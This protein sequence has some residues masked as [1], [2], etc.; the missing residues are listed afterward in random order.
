M[1]T[2][3]RLADGS[4][5]HADI[6]VV[7]SG[8]RSTLPDWL[9]AIGASPVPEEVE[10]TGIVYLSRFYRLRPGRDLPSRSGL[11]GGDL[12]YLKYG[13]FVGDNRTFSLTLAVP[14]DD[15]ELRRRLSEPDGFEAAARTLDVAAP[16][17]DG[18]AEALTPVHVMAGLLNRWRNFVIEGRPAALGVHAIGDALVCTN[19]LYG[20]GCTT[21]YWGAHLLAAAIEAAPDDPAEQARRYDAAVRAE[22][23]PWYTTGVA[24]DAEARRVAAALLAGEDPDGD[25]Q[26]PRAFMRGVLREGLA[27]ALRTD[28]VVLRAFMR[29]LNLLTSPNALMMDQEVSSRVLAVWQDREHRPPEPELGPATRAELCDAL[30]G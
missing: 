25:P 2:G 29:S 8:R 4:K 15:D 14:S 9:A 6:V 17:V 28:L 11:I 30:A 22:I 27:P 23:L 13:V 1:V 10:D 7:A 18:R 26:D 20:R 16:Y 19:P 21:G 24:Q 12:G 3:V 5:L